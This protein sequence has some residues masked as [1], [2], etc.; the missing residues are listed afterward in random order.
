MAHLLDDDGRTVLANFAYDA[1]GQLMSGSN[2]TPYG[3][4]AQWGYYTDVESGILLLTHRYLDPATGRFLT[5]DPIGLEGGINLYAY[6][7][8]GVVD[9]YDPEGELPRRGGPWHPPEKVKVGCRP[10]DECRLIRGKIWNLLRMLRSQKGWDEHVPLPRGGQHS[11]EIEDLEKALLRCLSL[12]AKKC[13]PPKKAQTRASCHPDMPVDWEKYYPDCQL[14]A[15]YNIE[16]TAMQHN[17]LLKKILEES[18]GSSTLP[19]QL[20]LSWMRSQDI[21]VMALVEQLLGDRR[22]TDRIRPPLQFEEYHEFLVRYIEQC[23]WRDVHNHKYVLERWEAGYRLVTYF[24]YLLDNPSLPYY[25]I[26]DLKRLMVRLF[27][28]HEL[29]DFVVNSVLEHVLEHPQAAKHFVD[30]QRHPQL[31]E[32]YE[33]AMTWAT[34]TPKEDSMLYIHKRFVEMVGKDEEQ[35]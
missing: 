31:R 28:R 32:A 3:Y 14:N 7:G 17:N 5:R 29:R 35:E 27:E 13:Q 1:W 16:A 25:A 2:P 18:R 20:V 33:Q 15:N 34:T 26:E 21:E 6:V 11:K 22:F 4:K 30:W 12:W 9:Y 24:W 10:S 23:I 19:R 8:N